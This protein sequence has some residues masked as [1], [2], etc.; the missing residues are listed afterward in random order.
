[1]LAKILS[2]R[3]HGL[4]SLGLGQTVWL[5]F[6]ASPTQEVR[7]WETTSLPHHQLEGS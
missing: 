4:E 2:S 1:M 3:V 5:L 7:K 6:W